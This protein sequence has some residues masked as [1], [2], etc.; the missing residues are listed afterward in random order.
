MFWTELFTGLSVSQVPKTKSVLTKYFFRA[1][2]RNTFCI[3]TLHSKVS[4]PTTA[5]LVSLLRSLQCHTSEQHN[6][7]TFHLKHLESLLSIPASE[8]K[9]VSDVPRIPHFFERLFLLSA[10]ERNTFP[11]LFA[12]HG[13]MAPEGALT[14]AGMPSLMYVCEVLGKA[15]ALS[16]AIEMSAWCAYV[17]KVMYKKQLSRLSRHTSTPKGST[18]TPTHTPTCTPTRTPTRTESSTWPSTYT[19][20]RKG[21][22]STVKCH[23]IRFL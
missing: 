21:C 11:P 5:L 16:L 23:I 4:T 20:T 22:K 19:S 18:R 14:N 6:T 9:P 15:S 1:I 3:H 10:F 2:S 12:A 8:V 7:P 13:G 17:L